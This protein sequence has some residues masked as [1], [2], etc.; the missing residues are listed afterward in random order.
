MGISVAGVPDLLLFIVAASSSSSFLFF[1]F[2]LPFLPLATLVTYL[3]NQFSKAQALAWEWHGIG[4]GMGWDGP[5]G[6]V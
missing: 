1:L 6:G 4:N 3:V 2:Y 5:R